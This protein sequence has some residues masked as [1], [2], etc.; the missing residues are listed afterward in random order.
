MQ[1]KHSGGKQNSDDY[2]V[3]LLN[4]STYSYDCLDGLLRTIL[5][6]SAPYARHNPGPV[7]PDSLDAWQ[8][9]G[10][11]ERIFWL[12]GR[13]GACPD[14]HLDQLANE[15]QSPAEYVMDSRH[16]GNEGWDKSFLRS[17]RIRFRFLPSNRPK[18]LQPR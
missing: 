1:G 14:L 12:V 6:R 13:P 11:Q 15:L 2:T 4:N 10:R 17:L 8:D 9:Q 3:A 18:T 16:G 5:I 7:D